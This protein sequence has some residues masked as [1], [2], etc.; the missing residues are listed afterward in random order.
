M[1][2]PEPH[3]SIG[4]GEGEQS[5]P[6]GKD[7]TGDGVP[8]L[9]VAEYMGGAHGDTTYR[10]FELSDRFRLLCSIE[11]AGG[12]FEDLNGDGKY[13][14]VS[15]D[16]TFA[17]WHTSYAESHFPAVILQFR[18]GRWSLATDLMRKPAPSPDEV[19]L[20]AS[21][22]LAKWGASADDMP[23]G[24]L[25]YMLDLIYTGQADTARQFL[26]IAW[27]SYRPGK[28]QFLSEFR[29]QLAKSS[30]W[31]DLQRLNSSSAFFSAS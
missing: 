24:L 10:V 3:F 22:V 17:Y 12:H 8:D 6:V 23:S 13:E 19:L 27:P 28:E 16:S 5:V 7:I 2:S 15:M 18:D 9:V 14:F 20:H 1:P 21:R 29:E 26:N 4:D 25:A 31:I 11:T 30:Y